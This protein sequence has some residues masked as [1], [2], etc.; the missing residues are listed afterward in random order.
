M[1]SRLAK[2]F[3]TNKSA[4][5]LGI[6]YEEVDSDGPLFQCR[7]ARLGG[8][9]KKYAERLNELMKP[10]RRMD[11]KDIPVAKRDKLYLQAFCETII[12]PG[13]WKTWVCEDRSGIEAQAELDAQTLMDGGEVPSVEEVVAKFTGSFVP[14]VENPDT[15]E[16]IPATPANLLTVLTKLPELTD[17]LVSEATTFD[18]YRAEIQEI[19]AKN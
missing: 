10:Y 19:E 4:E 3:A 1:T 13:S 17:R 9:N 18:N 7:L 14:G 12:V 6:L 15:G 8:S 2:K 11:Q 16:I 5:I